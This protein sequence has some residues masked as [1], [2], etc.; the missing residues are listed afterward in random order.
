MQKYIYSILAFY[1]F[2]Q[3]SIK[4][5]CCLS[6]YWYSTLPPL[7]RVGY[8]GERLLGWPQQVDRS[9]PGHSAQP[10]PPAVPWELWTTAHGGR[11]QVSPFPTSEWKAVQLYKWALPHA[12]GAMLINKDMICLHSSPLANSDRLSSLLLGSLSSAERN[13]FSQS[14]ANANLLTCS[15]LWKIQL[16]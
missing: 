2:I 11:S 12:H 5:P 4:T 1:S 15:T 7:Q 3:I 6:V 8:W 9:S 16:K 13:N 10:E 14:K